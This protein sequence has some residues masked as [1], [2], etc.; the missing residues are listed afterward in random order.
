MAFCHCSHEQHEHNDLGQ[1]CANVEVIHEGK[2]FIKRCGCVKYR[3]DRPKTL[4]AITPEELLK[5]PMTSPH[6][7]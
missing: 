5:M 7:M 3:E 6:Y 2:P 4:K 1:C